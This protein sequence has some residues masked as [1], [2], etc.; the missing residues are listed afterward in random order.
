MASETSQTLLGRHDDK[1][2]RSSQVTDYYS[3]RANFL[4]KQFRVFFSQ[5]DD[6]GHLSR[7]LKRWLLRDI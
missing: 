5:W 6:E 3:S 4:F 2:I 7:A 1:M